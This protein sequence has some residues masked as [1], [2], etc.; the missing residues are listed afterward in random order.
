MVKHRASKENNALNLKATH[1]LRICIFFLHPRVP[2]C[3]KG[4][5][6]SPSQHSLPLERWNQMRQKIITPSMHEL[7]ILEQSASVCHSL[8]CIDFIIAVVI[9]VAVAAK[10]Y[11]YSSQHKS[12]MCSWIFTIWSARLE[13]QSFA[14]SVTDR[15]RDRSMFFA[16]NRLVCCHIV[17]ITGKT[18]ALSDRNSTKR[19]ENR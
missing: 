10:N 7:I 19:I 2:V 4:I 6:L 1:S 9:N 16:I 5:P 18:S 3:I 14:Q 8:A 11:Y 15:F 12:T 13:R 17:A